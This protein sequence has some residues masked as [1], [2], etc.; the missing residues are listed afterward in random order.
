MVGKNEHSPASLSAMKAGS[1]GAW[2]AFVDSY[3]PSPS[4]GN[5]S[6]QF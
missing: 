4:S 1:E 5:C 2:D 3:W 6:C